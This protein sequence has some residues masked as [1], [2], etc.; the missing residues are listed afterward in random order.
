MITQKTLSQYIHESLDNI[1]IN[2]GLFSLIG[3]FFKWLFDIDDSPKINR[4]RYPWDYDD[5]DW[6]TPKKKKPKSEQKPKTNQSVNKKKINITEITN[7]IKD[8]NK[9]KKKVDELKNDNEQPKANDVTPPPIPNVEDKPKQVVT[10]PENNDKPEI[11]TPEPENT[12]NENNKED[13]P[14]KLI[15]VSCDDVT[16]INTSEVS[17]TDVCGNCDDPMRVV[18]QVIV[19][20]NTDEKKHT[21]LWRAKTL[22]ESPPSVSQNKDKLPGARINQSPW[23]IQYATINYVDKCVIGLVTYSKNPGQY[24][25]VVNDDIRHDSYMHVFAIE[26]IDKFK[27]QDS[28]LKPVIEHLIDDAKKSKV[29]GITIEYVND[30]EKRTYE[31][32]GFETYNEKK[33]LMQLKFES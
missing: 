22:I 1:M 4:G 24:L 15:G 20:S 21:G 25:S 2:E 11:V 14:K 10:P 29:R 8:K 31:K 27:K 23:F 18:Y 9:L 30:D 12:D 28:I 7:T 17:V 6:I 26:L 32:F 5:D 19:Q 33:K 13:K 3:Y 16:T